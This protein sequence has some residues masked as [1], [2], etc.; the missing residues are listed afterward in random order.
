VIVYPTFREA[1]AHVN[2]DELSARSGVSVESIEAIIAGTAPASLSVMMR[3]GQA[4]DTNPLDLFRLEPAM[5]AALAS[6]PTRWV[7][8]ADT[9]RRVAHA[10]TP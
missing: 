10:R 6:A 5:E 9:L 7:A 8:D 1:V 2:L 3:L 4:L